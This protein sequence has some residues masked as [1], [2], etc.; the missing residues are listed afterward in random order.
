MNLAAS[1]NR[2]YVNYAIVMFTS[3]CE[4]NPEH[5]NIYA[6]HSELL[7]ED[8]EK[9][10]MSLAKYDVDV[11][12]INVAKDV[13][14]IR[15]PSNENWSRETYYRLLLLDKLPPE[16]DRIFY[17]DIDVTV[18]GSLKELYYSDFE[19]ADLMACED[20]NK[21]NSL[22]SYKPKVREMLL[23]RYGPEFRYFNA[24]VLLL[25]IEQMRE[26]YSFDTYLN[27]MEEWN[28][29]MVAFDQDILN[30]VHYDKVKYINWEEYDVFARLAYNLGWTYKD[31]K[32]K[33]KIIHFAGA[34]PWNFENIHYE[35]ERFW[36][37]YAALTPVYK[38]L[39]ENFVEC[40]LTNPYLE[41]EAIRLCN[42][43]KEYAKAIDE[44]MQILSRFGVK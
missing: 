42:E 19:G 1:F 34:K 36:W 28:Y 12:F 33:N 44:A 31:V 13:D 24:G 37:E 21:R 23:P 43:N 16:V 3:F 4:N 29:Q 18:H 30:Y 38:E 6:L 39:L 22:D 20:S 11:V 5:N 8:F 32:E 40:A 2:K 7:D 41:N 15:L 35:I 10:E 26:N 14:G 25:N 9:V 27:A 17:L